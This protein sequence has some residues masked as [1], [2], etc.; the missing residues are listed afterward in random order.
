[1]RSASPSGSVEPEPTWASVASIVGVAEPRPGSRGSTGRRGIAARL[2]SASPPCFLRCSATS[3]SS[4]GPVV[5]VE[6]AAADQVV[7]QRPGLVA[8]PGLEGGDELALVDQA[9]LQREQA[10]EQVA[11]GGDGGHGAASR[12]VLR[13]EGVGT[14]DAVHAGSVSLSHVE[15][16]PAAPSRPAAFCALR[17][18]PVVAVSHDDD[19]E[20]SNR[21]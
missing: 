13:A 1:M 5:G 4:S 2:F 16:V 15:S 9:V 6:V 10:E 14:P 7:G 3:A 20:R 12:E 19:E 18:P 17:W 11:V 21:R 8:G